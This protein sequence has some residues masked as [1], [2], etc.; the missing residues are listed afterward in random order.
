MVGC[1][2]LSDRFTF[3]NLTRERE[4]RETEQNR[5]RQTETGR[6]RSAS[7]H[8]SALFQHTDLLP[9]GIITKVMREYSSINNE[10]CGFRLLSIQKYT[11][12]TFT[13]VG[14]SRLTPKA[15]TLNKQPSLSLPCLSLSITAGYLN[16][17]LLH[18][19]YIWSVIQ[20]H[21]IGIVHH[22]YASV[23]FFLNKYELWKTL[24]GKNFRRRNGMSAPFWHL[25]LFLTIVLLT[26]VFNTRFCIIKNMKSLPY[27]SNFYCV[28]DQICIV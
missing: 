13:S 27:E 24:G 6:K 28:D 15:V 11:L 17:N 18:N 23:F 14:E 1:L 10:L 26:T 12:V 9:P 8:F 4:K 25:R 16:F 19:I 3:I 5:E 2:S 21:C 22:T 20:C 7:F